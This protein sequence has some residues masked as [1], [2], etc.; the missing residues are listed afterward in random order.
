[1]VAPSRFARRARP[2]AFVPRSLLQ[3]LV[4][5]LAG[6][7]ALAAC[8]AAEA[9]DVPKHQG[10]PARIVGRDPPPADMM[11]APGMMGPTPGVDGGG[12]GDGG[13]PATG[14][15]TAVDVTMCM[16]KWTTDVW[17][18]LKNRCGTAACHAGTTM[19]FINNGTDAPTDYATL[20]GISV[21]GGTKPYIAGCMPMSDTLSSMAC[22][23]V[24]NGMPV[25]ASPQCGI[26]MP[27]S[28]TGSTGPLTADEGTKI[29]GW[30][31][32]GAPL[33]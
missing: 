29:A 14:A 3:A 2:F 4:L 9:A 23:L 5:V 21:T 1:M 13:A 20:K 17:P 32:C 22:N 24:I 30:L 26:Q 16:F 18:I 10:S 8:T 11:G 27:S 15:C 12:S 33:N 6:A 28:G 31:K 7:A 25:A 19:P